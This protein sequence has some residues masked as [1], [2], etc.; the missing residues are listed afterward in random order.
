VR[1]SGKPEPGTERTGEDQPATCDPSRRKGAAPRPVRSRTQHRR[2][3]LDPRREPLPTRVEDTPPLPAGY[4]S[5]LDAGLGA[6]GIALD[7]PA[8]AAIDGHVRLLL[9]WNRAINLTA[10]DDPAIAATAHVV[11][12]L[13]AL[14]TLRARGVRGLVDVGSG[15]GYPGLPLTV[16]LPAERAL[17]VESIAKKARFLETV[18]A[19][20]GQEG[21]V[22]IFAGRAEALAADR[23]QRER[24]PAVTVRAVAALADL[25]EL[26]FPLL[27]PGGILVAW[28]RGDLRGEL[29]AAGRATRAL[30]GGSVETVEV[31]GPLPG[32]RL[33]VVTKRGRTDLSFPRD[34][35]VRRRMPW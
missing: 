9:A 7:D 17:L 25:V 35:A 6:L 14:A 8:R 28:K 10:I 34:P 21:R 4:H 1:R 2:R 27:E 3:A 19:A 16:A 30:G 18:T 26:A 24:W 13:T 11:D 22:A 33:V 12:S 23:T 31:D 32:H 29:A 20:T 5:A 15:G